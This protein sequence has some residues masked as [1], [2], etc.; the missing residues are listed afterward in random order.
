MLK[1][2]KV[3]TYKEGDL[4]MI[5]NGPMKNI[6][7]IE[8]HFIGEMESENRHFLASHPDEAH[9]FFIPISIAYIVQYIYLPIITNYSRERIQRIVEDYIHVIANKYPYWNRS[10]GADH[11]LVSCHDWVISLNHSSIYITIIVLKYFLLWLFEFVSK[12][13][14]FF[15]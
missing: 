15:C 13:L 4:P 1:R 5:H 9:V 7:A 10:N 11:F 14:T 2:F 12:Y 8:G 3:W 6:Y